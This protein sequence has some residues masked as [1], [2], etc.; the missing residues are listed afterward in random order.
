MKSR[1]RPML[2][3][4]LVLSAFATAATLAAAGSSSLIDAVR[5]G[6][7]DAVNRLLKQSA[8]DVNTPQADGATALAWAAHRDDLETVSLLI[9][10]GAD[11]NAANV[12]GVTPLFLACTNRSDAVTERLLKAGADPNRAMATGVTPLM[13]C[14]RTGNTA[15]VKALLVYGAAINARDTER[16]QTALMRAA[17]EI[18]PAITQMLLEHGADIGARSARLPLYTPKVPNPSQTSPTGVQV[19]QGYRR[20]VYFPGFKGGLTALMFA[21]QSGDVESA[22]ALVA[23]GADLKEGTP[24]EGPPL[25]V[26]STNGR[27]EMALMLLEKGADP[28]ATDCYGMTAL[29]WALQEGIT[30][31][32][33]GPTVT[34]AFW[35]HAPMPRLIQALLAAG[36][37]PN[38]RIAK[39]FMT[40]HIHRFS[41]GTMLEPPQVGHAGGTPFLLAAASHNAEAMRLLLQ[42]G[43]DPKI[44]T[45]EGTTPLMVASGTGVQLATRGTKDEGLP[46]EKRL[47][48]LEAVR[49]AWE[50]GVDVNAANEGGRT[51]LHG[52]AFY[53]IAEVIEFLAS[54]G[55]DLEARDMYGQSAMSIA[56][57]D[58][59]GFIYRNLDDKGQDSTFHRKVLEDKKT[60]E[61]LLKLGAKPYVS[62]G[63]DLKEF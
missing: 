60:V 20:S 35:L 57:A 29:H 63:R 46:T 18:R 12:Y 19:H 45:F 33:S 27:E 24:E 43:A 30:A 37:N 61:L 54:K 6:D 34:D 52:A 4:V 3:L 31:I 36:A 21:A 15:A 8:A 13:E 48:A 62:T 55:A 14:V 56:L 1:V 38:A 32:S 50:S 39:D 53:G 25:V 59:D 47:R 17:A 40:Y 41:R 49:L 58:P 5:E 11:V 44:P 23:A 7:R 10:A 51:A 22:R 28:N 42:A 16:G 2:V 9:G 26:A